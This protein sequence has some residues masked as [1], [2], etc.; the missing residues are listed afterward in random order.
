MRKHQIKSR[1]PFN[2]NFS[3]QLKYNSTKFYLITDTE[4]WLDFD[5]RFQFWRY[6]IFLFPTSDHFAK[7]ISGQTA[8]TSSLIKWSFFS[9]KSS[10]KNTWI[11]LSVGLVTRADWSPSHAEGKRILVM[12]SLMSNLTNCN[13]LPIGSIKSY[14]D[15]ST[16]CVSGVRVKKL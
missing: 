14:V 8:Q 5:L 11:Q 16:A 4:H 2:C 13:A 6:L 7:I 15:I 12:I 1:F 10:L 9:V 3:K